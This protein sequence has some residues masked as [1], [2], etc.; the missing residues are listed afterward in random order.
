ML[1]YGINTYYGDS[2]S[3]M[4]DAMEAGA[5]PIRII[6]SPNATRFTSNCEPGKYGEQ[7]I[8]GSDAY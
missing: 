5:V 6:R 1:E 2:N 4:I 7:V 3:D 8:P